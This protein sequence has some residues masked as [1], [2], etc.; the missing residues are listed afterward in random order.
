MEETENYNCMQNKVI[1]EQL[2][3]FES[4][5]QLID[6]E[7]RYWSKNIITRT[8]LCRKRRQVQDTL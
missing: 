8:I 5:N 3:V 1:K 6:Q 4:H 7:F 2:Y